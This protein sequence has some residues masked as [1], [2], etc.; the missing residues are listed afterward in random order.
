[1]QNKNKR[2]KKLLTREEENVIL[3]HESQF[4]KNVCFDVHFSGC[5]VKLDR[6]ARI[7]AYK[8]SYLSGKDD[9][10]SLSLSL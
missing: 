5:L 1:M 2:N 8:S 4:H 6:Q 10:C 3:A 9:I 7:R